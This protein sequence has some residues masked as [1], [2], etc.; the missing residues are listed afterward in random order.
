MQ[1]C[2]HCNKAVPGDA[3]FC[4]YCG[5]NFGTPAV[6]GVVSPGV[7]S[8]NQVRTSDKAIA[9][10]ICGILFFILPAAIAAVVLGHMS[11]SEIGRSAGRIRGKGMATAGLVL[12]YLGVSIVPILIIAAIAIPNLLRARMASNEAS[13]VGALRSYNYAMGAYAARCPKIGFPKSLASLGSEGPGGC[14]A[15]GLLDNSLGIEFPV[16]SGYSF[17]Y[18]VAQPD[19]LGQVTRFVITADPVGQGTTGM[20]HFSIDQNSVMRWSLNAPPDDSSP[21]LR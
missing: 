8:P 2:P 15:A 17:H 18:S 12:G 3:Q 6:A 21:V 5:V 14:E 13:A 9:S 19:S 20:R 11:I 1:T 7:I 4:Q 10:F 16:K